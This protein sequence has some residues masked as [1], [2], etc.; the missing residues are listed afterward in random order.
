MAV[1]YAEGRIKM[2][3]DNDASTTDHFTIKGVNFIAAD[4]EGLVLQ[5][6]DDVDIIKMEAETGRLAQTVLFTTPIQVQQ[7]KAET[8]DG[9]QV[10]IYI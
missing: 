9:G 4:G 7:V 2:T 8:L 1:T 10:I 6:Q 3:A 5:D